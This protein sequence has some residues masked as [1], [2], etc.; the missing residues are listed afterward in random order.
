MWSAQEGSM[1]EGELPVL[2]IGGPEGLDRK[3]NEFPTF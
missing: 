3:K 2:R 1:W